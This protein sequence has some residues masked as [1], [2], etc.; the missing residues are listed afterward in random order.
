MSNFLIDGMEK[1][2]PT[3]RAQQSSKFITGTF[4]GDL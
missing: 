4:R 1:G 2:N 3:S